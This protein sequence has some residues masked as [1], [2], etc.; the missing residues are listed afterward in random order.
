[1]V[2]LFLFGIAAPV[3]RRIRSTCHSAPLTGKQAKFR[4]S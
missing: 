3:L 4:R 2:L 1:M